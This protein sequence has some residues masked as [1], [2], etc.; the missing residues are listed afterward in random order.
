MAG[1]KWVVGL[2]GF[3]LVALLFAGYMALAAGSGSRDD[4]LVTVS[5][6]TEELMPSLNRRLDEAI[7][8]RSNDFKKDMNQHYDTLMAELEAAIK[9]SGGGI[10][11]DLNDPAF[12]EKVAN[13]VAEKSGASGATGGM[14]TMRRVDVDSG[15][16][17]T[18]SVGGEALLRLGSATCV[19]TG[20]PGLV[21]TTDGTELSGGGA[22]LKNHLYLCTV[23]GRG[24]KATTAMTVFI[25][26]AYTIS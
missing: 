6:F 17:I 14:D 24:I 25:R 5:Y 16:T 3:L 15:K 12:I 9:K 20:T 10:T 21:D 13:A 22:L 18:L 2:S 23:E 19:A 26:G 1:K 8:A 11:G 7:A 4:P